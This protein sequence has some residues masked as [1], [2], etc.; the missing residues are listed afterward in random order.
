MVPR[1]LEVIESQINDDN[2]TNEDLV[3]LPMYICGTVR[4]LYQHRNKPGV[5]GHTL[6]E[7]E[8]LEIDK[9]ARRILILAN[10]KVH[11]DARRKLSSRKKLLED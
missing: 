1:W 7:A 8:L 10:K 5:A 4:A 11:G 2:T 6:T 9:E 3:D